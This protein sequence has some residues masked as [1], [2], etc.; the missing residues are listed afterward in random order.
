MILLWQ[1]EAFEPVHE[2]VGKEQKMEVGFV[3]RELMSGNLGQRIVGFQFFDDEFY[4][5]PIVV[6]AIDRERSKTKV[7]DES[8]IGAV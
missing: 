7:G 8:V 4:C 2:I 6:E 1:G 3:G 5:R